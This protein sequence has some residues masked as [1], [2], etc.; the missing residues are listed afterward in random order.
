MSKEFRKIAKETKNPYGNGNTSENI[1]KTMKTFLQS[2][3]IDLKKK[4][5]D[6]EGE[7]V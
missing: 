7:F 6:I 3:K 4:F 2:G 5:Y 1:V